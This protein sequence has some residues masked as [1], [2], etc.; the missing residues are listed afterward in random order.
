M[1]TAAA[2]PAT[3]PSH[4]LPGERT[5]ASR[6]RPMSRP[7]RYAA[8]SAAQTAMRTVN[9]ARCPWSA[10]PRR[11]TRYPRPSPIQP[12]PMTVEATATVGELRV[13]ATRWRR[14]A[15]P[16]VAV[17]PAS[18]HSTPP[19]CTPSSVRAKPAK[20]ARASGRSSRIIPKY[21]WSA[22]A[23]A[24]AASPRTHQPPSQTS[25]S[26]AGSRAATTRIRD[27]NPLGARSL[28]P[29]EAAAAARIVLQ[30]GAEIG[31]AE[32]GPEAVD[33][34]ELGV[35]ELPEEEVRDAKLAGSADEEIRVGHVG[36]VEVLGEEL[37]VDVL[38]L[39]AGLDDP[40]ERTGARPVTR[41]D[42]QATPPGPAAASVHDDRDRA[43]DPGEARL[44]R[45]ASPGERS[46]LREEVHGAGR[47][48]YTSMISASLCFRSSSI[49]F[50]CSSVSFWTWFSPRRSSSS[51]TSPFRTSSSR[52]RMTSRRTFRIAT[53]PSSA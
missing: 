40:P 4:V 38:G 28:S 53:L 30:C 47:G 16:N 19:S 52:C 23:P 32:V 41:R 51:P 27:Q 11:R 35:G 26:T 10:I 3:K 6:C 44:R 7:T 39:D 36:R 43:R 25:P 24:T 1:N 14:N 34:G 15:R 31:L 42:R 13:R 2:L 48:P 17:N 20:P 12:A 49:V 9:A 45:R 21:S 18:I 46:D 33:E 8:L 5:G 50:V 22:I 37:L 29:A